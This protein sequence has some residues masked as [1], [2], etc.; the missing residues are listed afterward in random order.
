MAGK[1]DGL[2]SLLTKGRS[3]YGVSVVL[4]FQ[5]IDSLR[6]P[7]LYG[8]HIANVLVG[9]CAAKAIFRLDSPSTARWASDTVGEVEGYE[10]TVSRTR[11]NKGES[12]YTVGEQYA[13]RDAVPPSAFLS[14]PRPANGEME[15]VFVHPD[16]GA[17]WNRFS[18]RELLRAPAAAPNLVPRPTQEQLLQPW[19]DDDIDRLGLTVPAEPPPSQPPTTRSLSPSLDDIPRMT[20]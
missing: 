19:D 5:D 6:A 4:G 8:E 17:Y 12:S 18:F 14:M 13:K 20:R 10:S 7:S 15:G 11:N 16:V 1:L 2:S 9:Q 3:P